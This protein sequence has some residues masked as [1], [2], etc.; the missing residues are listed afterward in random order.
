MSGERKR[1]RLL[2]VVATAGLLVGFR[3]GHLALDERADQRLV[4]GLAP[5]VRV[6]AGS[7]VMPSRRASCSSSSRITSARAA[8]LPGDDRLSPPDGAA[9]RAAIASRAMATP[10]TLTAAGLSGRDLRVGWA[11]SS[12][13]S[14]G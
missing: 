1:A 9:S 2:L 11:A 14:A 5:A 8:C 10:L 6:A 4:V 7:A 13:Y 3:N 12:L